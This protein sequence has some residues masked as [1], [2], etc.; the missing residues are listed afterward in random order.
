MYCFAT[1]CL[2]F[3][4]NV[5]LP[6]T[7][8]SPHEIKPNTVME[9]TEFSHQPMTETSSLLLSPDAH[10][11]T[12]R[13]VGIDRPIEEEG[14]EWKNRLMNDCFDDGIDNYHNVDDSDARILNPPPAKRHKLLDK[15]GEGEATTPPSQQQITPDIASE[16]AIQT[17]MDVAL[18]EGRKPSAGPSRS[19]RREHSTGSVS[20]D[21]SSLSGQPVEQDPGGKPVVWIAA[22][23]PSQ[24]CS[25]PRYHQPHHQPQPVRLVLFPGMPLPRHSHSIPTC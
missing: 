6:V 14:N 7:S 11:D 24:I 23:P 21:L 5:L 20:S 25:P 10:P 13:D 4:H 3:L 15:V 8:P 17:S 18:E 9:K 22:S 2:C 19:V 16:A 1:R 12:S